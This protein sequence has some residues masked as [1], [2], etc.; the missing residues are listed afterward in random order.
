M[1]NLLKFS[2][3]LLSRPNYIANVEEVKCKYSLHNPVTLQLNE[4]IS[5]SRI[6]CKYVDAENKLF[7]LC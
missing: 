4:I 1:L 7:P 5:Y 3:N 6:K 2:M